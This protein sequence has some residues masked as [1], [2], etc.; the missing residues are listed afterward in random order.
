M[1]KIVIKLALVVFATIAVSACGHSSSPG[2]RGPYL[3]NASSSSMVVRWRSNSAV[4]GS[5][6]YGIESGNLGETA[7]DN[8]E[9]GD[10]EVLLDGLS[11]DTQYFYRVNG[12]DGKEHSFT[13]PPV[14]GTAK[15]TRIWILGDSGTA[16]LSSNLVKLAFYEFNNGR[17]PDLM[18]LLGDSAYDSGTDVDYEDGFF[19]M[20]AATLAE[21]PVWPTLGNHDLVK[22]PSAYFDIFTLPTDGK[23]GGVPS[24]TEAYYSFNYSNIHFVSLDSELSSPLPGSDMYDWLAAD[25]SAATQD[26]KIVYF[27]RPPYSRGSHNSD[28]SGSRMA[29]IRENLVPVFETYGVDFVF[30]GHSHDYERSYPIR[31]HY[32]ASDTFLETMKSD[33]GDGRTDGDG[34]YRKAF[35]S[36]TYGVIYTVAGS[37]G[38]TGGGSLDHPAHFISLNELGSVALDIDGGSANVTFVSPAP[39]A[40][41]YYTLSKF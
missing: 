27:H 35:G 13:T 28:A 3:Q 24:G 39:A 31:G 33:P 26:W 19:G 20:Y 4:R 14:E 18:L 1:K 5:V 11:P 30:S 9:T 7:S 36:T 23:T 34:E 38:K 25:L 8:S 29:A 41:D 37:S 40:K 21:T 6:S 32:G 10:H 16:D 17:H 22:E 12:Q 2:P 15:P